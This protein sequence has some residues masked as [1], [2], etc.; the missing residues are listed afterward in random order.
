MGESPRFFSRL[1]EKLARSSGP[2]DHVHVRELQLLGRLPHG[3]D[4]TRIKRR[5]RRV[6]DFFEI[7][8]QSQ[9]V[10]RAID[11]GANRLRHLK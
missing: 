7:S 1:R 3:I 11:S 6:P 8:R 10:T 9:L 4:A 5:R 2:A